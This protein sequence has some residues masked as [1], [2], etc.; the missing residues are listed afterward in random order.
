[1][2]TSTEKAVEELIQELKGLRQKEEEAQE[3][4]RQIKKLLKNY[5]PLMTGTTRQRIGQ[6]L[7]PTR[8][9]RKDSG[10]QRQ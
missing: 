9:K 4:S 2:A 8:R 5:Q 6:A 3:R 1:M 7:N 10:S